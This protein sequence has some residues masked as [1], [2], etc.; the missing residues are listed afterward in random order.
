MR[1]LHCFGSLLLILACTLHLGC[2]SSSE[3]EEQ[4]PEPDVIDLSGSVTDFTAPDLSIR[5]S[6][7]DWDV[8]DDGTFTISVPASG[9]Y[10][11]AIIETAGE[12][13]GAKATGTPVLLGWLDESHTAIG[14]RSTAEVLAFFALGGY[15]LPL[16]V[17]SV[18]IEALEQDSAVDDVATAIGTALA[19]ADSSLVAHD[20]A[21]AQAI[22]EAL[23]TLSAHLAQ[24]YGPTDATK[25]M[26]I[27]PSD[28]RSGVHVLADASHINTLDI[29]NDYRRRGYVYID[30]TSWVRE[31]DG[32]TVTT[33]T[34]HAASPFWLEPT[35]GVGAGVL[36]VTED[37]FRGIYDVGTFA[38]QPLSAGLFELTL[39]D[40]AARADY[41]V[42]LVGPGTAAG[43][44][45][46]LPS[47]RQQQALFVG[48]YSLGV[49][50]IIPA[51]MSVIVPVGTMSGT[52][53][54]WTHL[55]TTPDAVAILE[56]I[57]NLLLAEPEI[58]ADLT[59]GH[60]TDALMRSWDDV[61]QGGAFQTLAMNFFTYAVMGLQNHGVLSAS[62]VESAMSA[63]SSMAKVFR[64]LEI[65]DLILAAGDLGVVV[66]HT[67]LSNM[68][69][70][71]T[72]SVLPPEVRLTP[73]V[74]RIDPYQTV[75]L[76]A[77][78][79][80]LTGSTSDV[81]FAYHWS[82]TGNNGTIA[83]ALGHSGTDFDSTYE[84]V[85]YIAENG[86]GGGDQVTVTV[87][88]VIA[89]STGTHELEL[90]D[91]T[92]AICVGGDCAWIWPETT[93]L[94]PGESVTLEMT[95]LVDEETGDA[96]DLTYTWSCD[97]LYGAVTGGGTTADSMLTYRAGFLP[98]GA[99]EV[100]TAEAFL[101]GTGGLESQ[102]QAS[103]TISV[104]A[105]EL[106]I[107]PV[108]PMI[109]PEEAVTLT[110]GV[111]PV[112]DPVLDGTLGY[113]WTCTNTYGTL[114]GSGDSVEYTAGTESGTDQAEVEITLAPPGGAPV[115]LGTAAVNIVVQAGVP[116]EAYRIYIWD[117]DGPQPLDSTRVFDIRV[118]DCNDDGVADETVELTIEGPGHF[119]STT[120]TTSST[121]R[122]STLLHAEGLGAARVTAEVT[123]NGVTETVYWVFGSTVTLSQTEGTLMIDTDVV[124]LNMT[125]NAG[126]LMGARLEYHWGIN[127]SVDNW[128]DYVGDLVEDEA[129]PLHA[130][131]Y[132]GWAP[133]GVDVRALGKIYAFWGEQRIILG[134]DFFEFDTTY[135]P[136]TASP[137]VWSEAVYDEEYSNY[138][139]YVYGGFRWAGSSGA[140][141]RYFTYKHDWPA[142]PYG[143]TWFESGVI[144]GN[145]DT[146]YTDMVYFFRMG[147]FA[148]EA[149]CNTWITEMRIEAQNSLSAFDMLEYQAIPGDWP[150]TEGMCPHTVVD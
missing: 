79:P 65:V 140:Q 148:D 9:G 59:A 132:T 135:S 89:D 84:F 28:A 26:Q 136:S 60:Y 119:E 54:I 11:M 76:T 102:G 121:G 16:D 128:Q 14:Y 123:S 138:K 118:F 40:G 98:V 33:G 43:D 139:G 110:A 57:T 48:A 68:A 13:A 116:G 113:S 88:Q 149:D 101:P 94:A 150:P 32:V 77:A 111:S 50:M 96:T 73:A 103:A 7:G 42:T 2:S 146:G 91:A 67:G 29:V 115:V 108:A 27:S 78:V 126:D 38:Y 93:N 80:E 75:T 143:Q 21:G 12:P 41:E 18:L 117:L 51:M 23:T 83:D 130:T 1:R 17:Q 46:S 8:S 37:I 144:C 74:S 141:F 56:D 137:T 95:V 45:M 20:T 105:P 4:Q 35:R 82:C 92:A 142:D 81:S 64:G 39:P 31:A 58:V 127:P 100:V 15:L 69:D 52:G 104:A 25:V 147:I 49:D 122:A 47:D 30:Q 34:P 5:T 129:N 61:V 53:D 97:E 70:V 99:D 36:S 124:E 125:L 44:L 109:L 6:L 71:W 19:T 90:G 120:L 114:T 3:P 106:G 22:R 85:E 134:F 131:L 66:A 72:I 112:P 63:T 10:Q 133:G 145:D 86:T 62:Q 55:T 87:T 24:L 107:D